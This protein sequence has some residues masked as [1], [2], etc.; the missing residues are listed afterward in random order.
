MLTK[1]HV[2]VSFYNTSSNKHRHISKNISTSNVKNYVNVTEP[3]PVMQLLSHWP[4]LGTL[5]WQTSHLTIFHG[6]G[7]IA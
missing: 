6:V 5:S 7:P 2:P 1:Q 3:L 4:A